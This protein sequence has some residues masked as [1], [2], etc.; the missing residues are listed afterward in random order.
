MK[1]SLLLLLLLTPGVES[2]EVYKWTDEAGDIHYGEKPAGEN[3]ENIIIPKHKDPSHPT[4][5]DEKQR[6]ENIQKWTAARQEEREKKK[7]KKAK[8]KEKKAVRK[9]RCNKMKNRLVDMQR[10]GRLYRLDE[11]GNRQY[12]SEEELD[13]KI[14]RERQL[15]K[16][17]C[18]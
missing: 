7:I 12:Y 15:I 1:Y 3:S 16:K 9:K 17:R 14:E 10:R 2:V 6:L 13:A 18:R 8:L 11:A 5:P 4:P